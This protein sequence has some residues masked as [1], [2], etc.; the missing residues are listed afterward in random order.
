LCN[1][2][3]LNL[4]LFVKCIDKVY[5]LTESNSRI[6]HAVVEIH[7]KIQY[8]ADHH[9]ECDQDEL[10]SPLLPS[11]LTTQTVYLMMD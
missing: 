3:V 5:T 4:A 10:V 7:N 9:A 8:P 2:E 1:I 6:T 11:W